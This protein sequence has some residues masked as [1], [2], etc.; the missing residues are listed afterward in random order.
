MS[1]GSSLSQAL[2]AEGSRFPRIYRAVVDAGLHAGRLPAALEG[3]TAYVQSY[4]DARQTIGTALSYPLMVFVLAYGVFV[5]VAMRVV[6]LPLTQNPPAGPLIGRGTLLVLLAHVLVV[7]P[8]PS[9]ETRNHDISTFVHNRPLTLAPA[10]A[11]PPARPARY[12]AGRLS[13]LSAARPDADVARVRL[14]PRRIAFWIPP[15]PPDIRATPNCLQKLSAAMGFTSTGSSS[16]TRSTP[17]TPNPALLTARTAST[18]NKAEFIVPYSVHARDAEPPV[19]WDSRSSAATSRCGTRMRTEN[20]SDSSL[21][22]I[23]ARKC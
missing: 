15:S 7:G 22:G 20:P 19:Q 5:W 21:T 3:L 4:L 18:P 1:E 9:L 2:E 6:V 14:R 12:G 13:A 23:R 11:T 17:T 8:Q 16:T 10:G